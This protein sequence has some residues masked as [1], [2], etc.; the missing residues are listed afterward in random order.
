L[1]AAI[2]PQRFLIDDR[3]GIHAAAVEDAVT[4]MG[5]TVLKTL[6]RCPQA[7]A[8]LRAA[9]RHGCGGSAWIG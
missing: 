9:D 4:A 6:V 8:F 2:S 5:L 7:N 3:D 1:C